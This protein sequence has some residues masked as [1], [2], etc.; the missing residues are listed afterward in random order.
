MNVAV[1]TAGWSIPS[2][3][4]PAFATDGSHLERYSRV[5]SCV[6]INSS[7]YRPH[8]FATYQRWATAVPS[9]FRF[10]VKLPKAISHTHRLV[11]V[12]ALTEAFAGETAGLGDK[13]EVVLVQLPPSLAFDDAV[14][15]HFF[16]CLRNCLDSAIACE[17]R[18]PSWFT[19]EADAR[20]SEQHIARVAADPAVA[21]G[22]GSPGGWS[23]FTYRR[24]HGSPRVYHSAYGADY[25][26]KLAATLVSEQAVMQR[27]WCI[28]DNTA[29]G[30]ATA[31]G[32]MLN[33]LINDASH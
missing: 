9:G 30:A 20:L 27:Q 3:L 8:R 10:A 14:A 16:T 33:A 28:F 17:P 21:T 15:S 19:T 1:G 6:E 11:D 5:M 2:A 26:D 12:G 18:H 25:I 4:T 22:A 13:R 32:I 24:L 29:S 7:F 23:G 31:D